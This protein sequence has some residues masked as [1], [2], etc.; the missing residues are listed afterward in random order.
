MYGTDQ[1]QGI[2][3]PGFSRASSFC[4]QDQGTVLSRSTSGFFRVPTSAYQEPGVPEISR[5][6]SVH[7]QHSA[8]NQLLVRQQSSHF[9]RQQSS[10]FQRQQSS[11]F[12]PEMFPRLESSFV[13]VPSMYDEPGMPSQHLPRAGSFL[14]Q[15]SYV[16]HMNG[17]YPPGVA[18]ESPRTQSEMSSGQS[19]KLEGFNVAPVRP[20]SGANY[21]AGVSAASIPGN[22]RNGA[23]P[24][25]ASYEQLEN[26]DSTAR[27]F[28]NVKSPGFLKGLSGKRSFTVINKCS[29]AVRVI[30]CADPNYTVVVS[31][32][33]KLGIGAKSGGPWFEIAGSQQ[34]HHTAN[35]LPVSWMS[36]PAGQSTEINATTKETF[37]T[38]T[39]LNK[40]CLGVKDVSVRM[41][42]RM[43]VLPMQG[44]E[45]LPAP[46]NRGDSSVML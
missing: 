32:S 22:A 39:D 29:F 36:L 20:I 31:R 41:N 7:T 2:G 13:C 6:E 11:H 16:Q 10:H 26:S 34:N 25:Y 40:T 3:G 24:L 33:G 9:Q 43:E 18:H 45:V 27:V 15:Q 44:M 14:H 8:L 23:Q 5:L 42:Q 46:M 37:V 1:N 17:M 38:L 30:C 12:Q 35:N 4:Y 19:M 28:A 21:P